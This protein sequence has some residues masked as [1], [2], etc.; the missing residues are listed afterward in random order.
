[1]RRH[2]RSPSAKMRHRRDDRHHRE[3]RSKKHKRHHHHHHHHHR[4]SDPQADAMDIDDRAAV[5]P[6]V[7]DVVEEWSAVQETEEEIEKQR[8]ERRRRIAAIKT[9]H[10]KS[11][12]TL[13]SRDVT[14][15]MMSELSEEGKGGEVRDSAVLREA[16]PESVSSADCALVERRNGVEKEMPLRPEVDTDEH[17]KSSESMERTDC[18]ADR[19]AILNDE[20]HDKEK[21][22]NCNDDHPGPNLLKDDMD[23]D[24]IFCETPENGT[25]KTYQ[26]LDNAVKKAVGERWLVVVRSCM[27][28]SVDCQS[29]I[30]GCL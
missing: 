16:T 15:G 7:E 12:A 18:S 6:E 4:S 8:E 2:A 24:D 25:T 23:V 5:A 14:G 3:R 19:R 17:L 11:T 28:L 1:M 29:R 30:D 20:K 13:E 21:L 26:G 10:Q 27:G 9:K 22:L